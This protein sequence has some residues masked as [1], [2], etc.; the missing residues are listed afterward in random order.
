MG[1]KILFLI[2]TLSGGGAE[3][4][5]V[6]IC[7]A[8]SARG[9][10]I[11]LQTIFDTGIH[12]MRIHSGV[13][14]IPGLP[15]F[16]N[17][18]DTLIYRLLCLI[19]ARILYKLFV[20]DKYDTEIAFL[21]G[22]AT[23]VI[24]G[25]NGNNKKIAWVHTDMWKYYGNQYVFGTQEK[26]KRIYQRFDKIFCVSN[27]AKRGF[28]KRF[29]ISKGVEV[30]YNPIDIDEIRQKANEGT[31]IKVDNKSLNVVTV[32]RLVNQK[33]YDILLSAIEKLK[34]EVCDTQVKLYI[35]GDGTLKKQLQDQIKAEQLE[36]NVVLCGYL[37]NPYPVIFKADLMVIS[38]R[39][40][41]YP[42]A[43][44]EGL[45]LGKPILST[46]CVG[47]LEILENGK[48][49][50]IVEC[51]VEGIFAGLKSFVKNPAL[52]DKYKKLSIERSKK[53]QFDEMVGKI[54]SAV[55]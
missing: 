34:N 46:N 31:T 9:N 14:Y 2:P 51:S 6:D 49:G 4:I 43:L 42:L 45:A 26:N 28:F 25:G 21:E 15:E 48:Y 5:L 18:L 41:G 12:K 17:K 33:G 36:E 55:V 20:H 11:T 54:E 1:K 10:D 8:L 32:G 13:T 3:K 44:C 53:F 27:D 37:E 23:K 35:I 22:L 19:P 38:S 47:P 39:V 16:K 24:G 30:M 50:K 29:G 52:L 40:E 7:N